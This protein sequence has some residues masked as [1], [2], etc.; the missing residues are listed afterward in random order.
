MQTC[1]K[2]HADKNICMPGHRIQ[3]GVSVGTYLHEHACLGAL[4]MQFRCRRIDLF[5]VNYFDTR[6]K[7]EGLGSQCFIEAVLDALPII[8]H[9]EPNTAKFK[10]SQHHRNHH[11]ICDRTKT[12]RCLA[13]DVES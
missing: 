4:E 9:L 2:Q 5:Q 8:D 11:L 1:H 13:I 6:L 12:A 10:D 7:V 3:R